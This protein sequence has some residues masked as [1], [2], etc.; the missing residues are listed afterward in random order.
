VLDMSNYD[1]LART[2]GEYE[3]LAEAVAPVAVL[4]ARIA[5]WGTVRQR[6]ERKPTLAGA[7]KQAKKLGVDVTVTA[8][9][10]MT[11]KCGGIPEIRNGSGN[12]ADLDRELEEWERRHGQA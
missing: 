7:L 1:E 4:K 10:S 11:F 6:R 9:G 8:D 3:A 2:L 12:G 5:G